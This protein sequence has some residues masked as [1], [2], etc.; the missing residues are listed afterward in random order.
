MSDDFD[1]SDAL[2]ERSDIDD[3]FAGLDAADELLTKYARA[4]IAARGLDLDRLAEALDQ[5]PNPSRK[6]T[7]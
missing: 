1:V 4:A 2:S 3:L 5:P 7:T 6:D